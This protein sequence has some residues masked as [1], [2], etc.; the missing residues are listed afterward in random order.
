MLFWPLKILLNSAFL[1]SKKYRQEFIRIFKEWKSIGNGFKINVGS[2]RDKSKN[3]QTQWHYLNNLQGAGRK[4]RQRYPENFSGSVVI[5]CRAPKDI[6]VVVT[7]GGS[8]KKPAWGDHGSRGHLYNLPFVRIQ[9]VSVQRIGQ[10]GVGSPAKNQERVL[11]G[12]HAMTIPPQGGLQCVPNDTFF[13]ANPSPSVAREMETKEWV[14][15][16]GAHLP[17]ENVPEKCEFLSKMWI[18]SNCEFF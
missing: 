9:V 15:D 4:S 1:Q 10:N 13:S 2:Q 11:E 8:L 18:L 12:H 5:I 14:G 17:T 6:H 16:L 7:N 3:F